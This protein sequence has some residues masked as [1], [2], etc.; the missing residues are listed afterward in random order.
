[1][2]RREFI[3]LSIRSN[4]VDQAT[5]AAVAWKRTAVRDG[6]GFDGPAAVAFF[7]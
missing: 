5:F 2:K 6:G 1:M 7:R 3:A 4:S